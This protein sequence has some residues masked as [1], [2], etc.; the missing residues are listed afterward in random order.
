MRIHLFLVALFIHT[1]AFSQRIN[2][3]ELK[4]LHE[5]EQKIKPYA[6]SMIL[7]EDW[8]DRFH[9][10]ASFTKGLVEAL[11]VTNS[12]FYSFDSI[13]TVSQLYAPDSSFKIFTW[14]L[15]KDF[16]YY[17]QKGAIQM[18]TADGSLRLYPLFDFS[19]FTNN[20]TD[21]IRNAYHWIGAIYYK[22]I[23]K[24]FLNNNYYT[25][26]GSD[27]N[28]ERTNKKWMDVL[29]FND[30]GLPE[31][32]GNFFIYPLTDYTK[33]KPPVS[34]F[35]LEYKKDAGARMNYDPKYDAIIFSHL[36]TQNDEPDNKATF[37]PYGDYEGFRWIN[38]KWTFV[39]DPFKG[40]D[41]KP[42]A[43]PLKLLDDKGNFNEKQ[44]LEQSKKNQQ[45]KGNS[46][47]DNPFRVNDSK[48][49]YQRG[50]S[51]DY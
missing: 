11:K 22:I 23:E 20:P 15:M 37:I 4:Q 26:I 31:F 10:D 21:S 13:K 8:V 12:F 24:T 46:A 16:S 33:P 32:G 45:K 34:R 9:A 36:V 6:D 3:Q 47:K 1:I 28:N 30:K 42:N 38:G 19:E 2:K 49:Q 41:Q 5:I 44:L 51:T 48:K 39:D 17:R 40:F 50:E 25:L 43:A 14:Q 27:E 29:W 18:K 7:A 35:C